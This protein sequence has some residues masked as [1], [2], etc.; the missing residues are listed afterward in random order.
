MT[1]Q[2]DVLNFPQCCDFGFAI[3]RLVGELLNGCALVG[4]QEAA[5]SLAIGV[6]SRIVRQADAK[7]STNFSVTFVGLLPFV[8]QGGC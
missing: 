4:P 2:C 6:G 3:A 7:E 5:K 1:V 8:L